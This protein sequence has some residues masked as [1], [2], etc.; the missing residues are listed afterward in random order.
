VLKKLR[1]E[2]EIRER[3]EFLRREHA[4]EDEVKRKEAEMKAE[5]GK[6]ADEA[7]EKE[8]KKLLKEMEKEWKKKGGK[9]RQPQLP[10]E[11]PERIAKIK[12]EETSKAMEVLKKRERDR[13]DAM[14]REESERKQ[15]EYEEQVRE[16][17]NGNYRGNFMDNKRHGLGVRTYGNGDVYEGL[18]KDGKREGKGKITFKNG[19]VYEV[20]FAPF[21]GCT[22]ICWLM[23][24]DPRMVVRVAIHGEGG[25]G[26]PFCDAN[27]LDSENGL[28][29]RI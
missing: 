1:E 22:R 18:W 28:G 3:M 12:K 29:F 4:A 25:V 24:M 21:S 2:Q 7:M 11:R 17:S 14:I 8:R 15:A 10:K 23:S 5:A 26:G 9:G 13:I 6:M 27:P 16:L 20:S 19:T